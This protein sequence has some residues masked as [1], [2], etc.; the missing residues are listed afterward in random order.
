MP[1]AGGYGGFT[2]KDKLNG[3][4]LSLLQPYPNNHYRWYYASKMQ[5][6]EALLIKIFDTNKSAAGGAQRTLHS[7]FSYEEVEDPPPR[8]SVE[9]R[10]MV[11][12]EDQEI[13]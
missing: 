8:Q 6:K 4:R 9:F 13:E 2:G 10:T 7:A 11:F 1:Q 5:P 12:W 3:K